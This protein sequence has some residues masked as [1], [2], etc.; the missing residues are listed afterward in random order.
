MIGLLTTARNVA[1]FQIS[2]LVSSRFDQLQILRHSEIWDLLELLRFFL[3]PHYVI[4]NTAV[5][6]DETTV[7]SDQVSDLWQQTDLASKLE[8]GLIDITD[9]GRKWLVDFNAGRS[10][11]ASFDWSDDSGANWRVCS[12]SKRHILRCLNS[13]FPLQWIGACYV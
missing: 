8:S 12:W 1:S 2:S 11:L 7:R 9:W 5:Y 3:G 13:L 6:T 10:H 4:C